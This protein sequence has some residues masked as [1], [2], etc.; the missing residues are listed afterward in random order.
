MILSKGNYRV[1]SS[2]NNEIT[3]I[4]S[5]QHTS[6]QISRID[7]CNLQKQ[8]ACHYKWPLSDPCAFR[9]LVG[10]WSIR[11][12]WR[13]IFQLL[14]VLHPFHCIPQWW[15]FWRWIIIDFEFVRNIYWSRLIFSTSKPRMARVDA[16]RKAQTHIKGRLGVLKVLV[17]FFK[18]IQYTNERYCNL[19]SFGHFLRS[20]WFTE[21]G[22]EFDC[23]IYN[24]ETLSALA[25]LKSFQYMQKRFLKNKLDLRS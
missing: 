2:K 15:K 25:F 3:C 21:S 24:H 8:K 5:Q 12:C 6:L 18:N 10:R 20:I 17:F 19:P 1:Y 7:R 14:P 16:A 4:H 9:S 22:P 23:H 11:L 13:H